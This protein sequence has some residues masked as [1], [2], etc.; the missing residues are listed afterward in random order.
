MIIFIRNFR[1]KIRMWRLSP[2]LGDR[3]RTGLRP[4]PPPE[5]IDADKDS[6]L[7]QALQDPF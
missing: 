3:E 5:R 2:E 1:E 7:L 6:W 4:R